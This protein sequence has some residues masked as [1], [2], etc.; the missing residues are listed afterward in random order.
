[1][2]RI[3]QRL[4]ILALALALAACVAPPTS[5][6]SVPGLEDVPR[7]NARAFVDVV[8][9]VEPIAEQECRTNSP[10]LNCDFLIVVDDSPGAVPNAFQTLDE[11]GRPIIAF[12]AS[13]LTEVRNGDELAF[14]MAH[15]AAHHIAGHLA[16]QQRNAAIGA[17]VFGRIAGQVR[18]GSPEAIQNAQQLG[19]VVGARRYSQEFEL[20]ADAL[21]TVIAARAG[22]DPVRGAQ[23]FFRLPDP[24]NRILGTHPPNAERVEIV[25]QTAAALGL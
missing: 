16:R 20:E 22:F 19:A 18:G 1:M 5:V 23:F 21:G 9:R 13:L 10:Q 15:E 11:N 14:I 7:A 8:G 3:L 17:L 6:E 24:G 12:T 25:N 4:G 2:A